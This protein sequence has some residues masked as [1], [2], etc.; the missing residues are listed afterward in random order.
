MGR[1]LRRLSRPVKDRGFLVE[2]SRCDAKVF[3]LHHAFL[4]IRYRSI[5]LARF[6]FG[7]NPTCGNAFLIQLRE[8]ISTMKNLRAKILAAAGGS[9][10]ERT[11]ERLSERP[12][13]SL[14]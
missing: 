2:P 1:V 14:T 12:V 13:E 3:L 4:Q 8:Q 10:E 9:E 5:L 11:R 6:A 7:G